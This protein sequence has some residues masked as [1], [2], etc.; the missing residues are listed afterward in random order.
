[1]TFSEV[2]SLA[3]PV[4][5]A[6]RDGD[7]GLYVVERDGTI[8]RLGEGEPATVLDITDLTEGDGERGLLGLAFDPDGGLAYVNYTDNRGWTIIA[9]Y[10]VDP[11]GTFRDES[12]VVL[13]IEQPYANHNGGDL[14]FGPDGMLY[15]GMGDGGSGGDPERRA[16]DMSSLLGK[17]LRIDP[18]RGR[19]PGVLRPG[20]QPVRRPGGR[21]AGD[22][23]ERSAQ[24]MA[25]LVR[26]GD[27]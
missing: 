20:R 23:V 9:E 22:L 27:R 16:T 19:R 7:P 4:D 13:E 26:P 18:G 12:R 21:G 5:L 15:I 11:D 6:W 10:P 14:T 2:V 8:V 24:P 1:M 17:L 25:L 3:E